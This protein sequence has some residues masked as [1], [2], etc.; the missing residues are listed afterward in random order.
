MLRDLS[1]VDFNLS[2]S[3]KV[4]CDGAIGLPICDLLLV[5]NCNTWPNYAPL[6]DR[7]FQCLTGSLGGKFRTSLKTFGCD[8]SS[9]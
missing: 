9:E 5:F 4:K 3:L 6:R 2:R 1:D 8:L 7:S